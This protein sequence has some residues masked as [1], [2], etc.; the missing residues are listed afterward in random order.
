MRTLEDLSYP[1]SRIDDLKRAVVGSR[2]VEC[3]DQLANACRVDAR[4]LGQIQHDP[5]FSLAKQSADAM[6]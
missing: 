6:S 4:D 3:P 2:Y 5:S 1:F